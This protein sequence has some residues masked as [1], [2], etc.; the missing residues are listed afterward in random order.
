MWKSFKAGFK[1]GI[2]ILIAGLVI[3]VP[4]FVSTL[5]I[6]YSAKHIGLWTIPLGLMLFPVLLGA[7][8]SIRNLGG[9][10]SFEK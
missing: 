7:A 5:L 4:V 9:S 8:N 10:E 2:R 3:F 1:D 6:I